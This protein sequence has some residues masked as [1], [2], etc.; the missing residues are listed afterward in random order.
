MQCLPDQLGQGQQRGAA[1][2]AE[3]SLNL[4]WAQLITT[5]PWIKQQ[6]LLYFH[7]YC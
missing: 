6:Y 5:K 1:R 2:G 7:H 3:P 4:S